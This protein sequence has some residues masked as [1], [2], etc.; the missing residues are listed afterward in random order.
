MAFKRILID[1]IEQIDLS[2]LTFENLRV[3]YG[4][5]QAVLLSGSGRN[6]K[7]GYRSGIQTELGDIEISVWRELVKRLVIRNN[8]QKLLSCYKKWLKSTKNWLKPEEIEHEALELYT[9]Q[10]KDN[11]EW[12]DYEAFK[13]FWEYFKN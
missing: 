1:R 7:Y 3:C 2:N 13:E 12:Y 4:T 9:Y 6:K 8:D 5:G 11:T 10:M